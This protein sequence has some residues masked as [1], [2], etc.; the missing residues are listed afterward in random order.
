MAMNL[1]FFGAKEDFKRS[2][3][4]FESLKNITESGDVSEILA[5]SIID[6]EEM[7][8][9]ECLGCNGIEDERKGCKISVSC[10]DDA[11]NSI[12]LVLHMQN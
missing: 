12:H 11:E 9:F 4:L 8:R 7:T 1:S 6:N 10:G 3:L 2:P 5:F